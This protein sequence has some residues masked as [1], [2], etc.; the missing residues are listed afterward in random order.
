MWVV[1]FPIYK[2]NTG[3]AIFYRIGAQWIICGYDMT[4]KLIPKELYSLGK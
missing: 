2:F 1:D 3:S 4:Q